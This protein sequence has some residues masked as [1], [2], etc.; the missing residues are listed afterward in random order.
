MLQPIEVRKVLLQKVTDA[1]GL[2]E[3]IDKGHLPGR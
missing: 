3:L 2:E 1:S